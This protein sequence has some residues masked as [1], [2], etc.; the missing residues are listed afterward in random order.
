M[1]ELKKIEEDVVKEVLKAHDSV[2]GVIEWLITEVHHLL[3]LVEG[4]KG[5]ASDAVTAAVDPEADKPASSES[6]TQLTLDPPQQ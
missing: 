4:I 1:S 2:H 3:D 5:E 6:A